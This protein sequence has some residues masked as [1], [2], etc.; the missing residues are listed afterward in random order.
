[1]IESTAVEDTLNAAE[2]VRRARDLAIT[3]AIGTSIVPILYI[4]NQVLLR[5]D[6]AVLITG[7]AVETGL[8]FVASLILI[9]RLV[10]AAIDLH[11]L[12]KNQQFLLKSGLSGSAHGYLLRRLFGIGK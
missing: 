6:G 11:S 1:M 4:A 2:N 3:S 10:V 7:Y 12:L 9:W 8:L 5:R